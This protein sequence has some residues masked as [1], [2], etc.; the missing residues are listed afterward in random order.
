MKDIAYR[1][2]DVNGE[3]YKFSEASL[4]WGAL[5]KERVPS[6]DPAPRRI[7]GDIGAAIGPERDRAWCCTPAKGTRRVAPCCATSGAMTN[8]LRLLPGSSRTMTSIRR[9]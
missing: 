7:P 6:L 9:Y 8:V 1:L 3:R 2:A 5:L 4:R